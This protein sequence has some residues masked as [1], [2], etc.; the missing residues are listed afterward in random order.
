[1]TLSAIFAL[2]LQ[3]GACS[4]MHFAGP[5][6]VT[7]TVLVCPYGPPEPAPPPSRQRL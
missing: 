2:L 1:M 6:H 4:T 3:A 7:L 5:N